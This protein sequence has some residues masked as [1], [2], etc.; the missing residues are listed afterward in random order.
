LSADGQGAAAFEVVARLASGSVPAALR[1]AYISLMGARHP[2]W[3]IR[4]RAGFSH[5]DPT[6]S[7]INLSL[8]NNDPSFIVH[9]NMS[10]PSSFDLESVNYRQELHHFASR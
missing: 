7:P 2:Q 10:D 9:L 8:F 6:S 4:H 1:P 5:V 3:Y